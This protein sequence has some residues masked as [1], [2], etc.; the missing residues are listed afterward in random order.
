MTSPQ[1]RTANSF[2]AA[3]QNRADAYLNARDGIMPLATSE[4]VAKGAWNTIIVILLI[5]FSIATAG[6]FVP[7]WVA[8][9]RKVPNAG[10]VAV[11]DILLGWT[12]IGWAV[13]L[14]M[15]CRSADA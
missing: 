9:H 10:S 1:H 14:A 8:M 15:A 11:I 7:I 3:Y 2:R 6:Y 13:A 4:K 5:A 12:L